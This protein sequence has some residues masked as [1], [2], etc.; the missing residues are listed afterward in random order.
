LANS[1][2]VEIIIRPGGRAR[3]TTPYTNRGLI[4]LTSGQEH[5]GSAL[6]PINS[7]LLIPRADRRGLVILSDVAYVLV[8]GDY[9]IR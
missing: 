1:G 4:N 5:L 8:R 2:T 7:L 3:V 6:V 9:E